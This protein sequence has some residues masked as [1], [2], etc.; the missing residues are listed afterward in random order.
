HVDGIVDAA[1]DDEAVAVRLPR[2]PAEAVRNLKRLL[3]PRAAT[4]DG[5]AENIL[6][7]L[8]RDGLSVG[9]IISIVAA[10]QNQHF[11]LVGAY[12]NRR[13]S[14]GNVGR[15]LACMRD[16][17]TEPGSGRSCRSD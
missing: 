2:D 16:K 15:K 11:A 12:R 3:E 4:V 5:I 17:G 8:L 13:G 10:C 14:V 9:A 1:A 6:R 7:G